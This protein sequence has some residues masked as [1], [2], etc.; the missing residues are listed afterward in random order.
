MFNYDEICICKYI[1]VVPL[2]TI[3]C[4]VKNILHPTGLETPSIPLQDFP[5]PYCTWKDP[6]RKS[7]L[8]CTELLCKY[9]WSYSI[10]HLLASLLFLF[11]S[12]PIIVFHSSPLPSHIISAPES[13]SSFLPFLS[14][15]VSYTRQWVHWLIT[16]H[17]FHFSDPQFQQLL[18]S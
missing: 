10:S 13:P 1:F 18:A 16:T 8:W 2:Q 3:T 15:R 12:S 11:D 5:F 7:G 17:L 4:T 14:S 6:E 9:W